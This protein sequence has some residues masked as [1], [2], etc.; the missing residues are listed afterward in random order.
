[1]TPREKHGMQA[2][3]AS[4]LNH[5]KAGEKNAFFIFSSN[6]GRSRGELNFFNSE[7]N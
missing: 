2:G 3:K 1:M 5:Q 4:G 6:K 7:G